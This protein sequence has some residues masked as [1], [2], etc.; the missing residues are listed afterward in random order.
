MKRKPGTI[1][2]SYTDIDIWRTSFSLKKMQEIRRTLAKRANQRMVR[3]ER[4]KSMVTGESLNFGAIE[5]ARDYLGSRKRFSESLNYLDDVNALR[6]EISALQ[7][8]L[9]SKT[10][11][12]AGQ[13]EIERNRISSFEKG[14]WG[15]LWHTQGIRQ[16]PISFASNKEFYDFLKSG[17]FQGLVKAGID[18]DKLV[19][20]FETARQ[21]SKEKDG[22]IRS[23]MQDAL[24]EFRSK[25]NANLKDLLKKTGIKPLH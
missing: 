20:I 21:Q 6:H 9:T 23:K 13:R 12:I 16:K 19:E 2:T 5:N 18:S 14:E 25:G 8:F 4:G 7:G 15:V 17:T 3:L 11:T 10:S 22:E 1:E 24:D